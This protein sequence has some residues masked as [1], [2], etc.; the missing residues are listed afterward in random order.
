MAVRNIG[1]R[2]TQAGPRIK[3]N[4]NEVPFYQTVPANVSAGQ[5][6]DKSAVDNTVQD[7]FNKSRTRLGGGQAVTA[8]PQQPVVETMPPP[9]T[10]TGLVQDEL[11]GKTLGATQDHSVEFWALVDQLEGTGIMRNIAHMQA[12]QYFANKYPG[13]TTPGLQTTQE[14]PATPSTLPIG[15]NADGGS[16][17]ATQPPP[18]NVHVDRTVAPPAG[19][20]RFSDEGIADN[21]RGIAQETG[22][23]LAWA[24]WDYH[25]KMM[26][27]PSW[28]H[29]QQQWKNLQG[30]PTAPPAGYISP[31]QRGPSSGTKPDRT[32][33][34][35]K[36]TSPGSASFA[37][38][39]DSAIQGGARPEWISDATWT[40]M[41]RWASILKAR[42]IPT[43]WSQ[44]WERKFGNALNRA[45]RG[46]VPAGSGRVTRADA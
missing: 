13:W 7:N 45:W 14:A 15:T 34:E 19:D 40:Q 43:S 5:P 42:G 29:K 44:T 30:R 41:Q 32:A 21:I 36:Y 22:L 2:R 31:D 33:F 39:F 10:N 27:L 35:R 4:V 3:S 24:A 16:S 37:G 8:T 11:K 28:S 38:Y 6:V 9:Q 46:Y 12:S 26:A 25:L 23:P 20:I 18:V 1:R 17:V